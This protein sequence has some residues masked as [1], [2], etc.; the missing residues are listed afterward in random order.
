[1]GIGS[2][3]DRDTH[4]HPGRA[5]HTH[6]RRWSQVGRGKDARVTGENGVIVQHRV[7]PHAP[8]RIHG[9]RPGA[10]TVEGAFTST[11]VALEG[12]RAHMCPGLNWIR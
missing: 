8:S 10:D 5:A 6:Q 3:I 4:S 1:M 11:P 7:A 9:G 2:Y 12:R